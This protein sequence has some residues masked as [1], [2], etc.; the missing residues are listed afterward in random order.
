MINPVKPN[1]GL[2]ISSE[3]SPE[4]PQIVSN[5]A[6]WKLFAVYVNQTNLDMKFSTK[7]GGSQKSGGLWPT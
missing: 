5:F 1:I 3:P 2:W 6:G 7:L 4:S